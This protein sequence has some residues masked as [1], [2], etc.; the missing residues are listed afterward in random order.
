MT[1]V[2]RLWRVLTAVSLVLPLAF[3]FGAMSAH[4]QTPPFPGKPVRIVVPYS[5]GLGPDVVMRAVAEK[6]ALTWQQPVIVENRPGASGVVALADVRKAA[7]DG[8]TLFLGDAGSLAVAP[9]LHANLPYDPVRDF[10][11]VTTIFRATFVLWTGSNNRLDSLRDL[12]RDAKARPGAVTYASF[13]AG[14][15]SELL[16]ESF[17]RSAGVEF[18]AVRFK[19]GGQM[20]GAAV[21]GDVDVLPLSLHSVAGMYAAG[22]LKPLA[23]GSKGR[24]KDLPAVPTIEEA[25][26]PA[27]QMTPWAALLAV[28]GTPAPV[29]ERIHRDVVAALNSPEVRNRVEGLGF[30]VLGSTPRQLADLIRAE[31]ELYRS[32][33]RDGRIRAE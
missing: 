12:L 22:K 31:A 18:L 32:L 25:G 9:Y 26:G 5:V 28:A 4:A 6:L 29:L 17:A 10:A 23:V 8:H 1:S 11:P 27:M 13:G 19:D 2:R 30:D 21:T 24:L 15:V 7:A 14:H 20:I 3:S 33:V 16:M